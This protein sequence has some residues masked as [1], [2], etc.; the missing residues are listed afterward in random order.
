M[1]G[2]DMKQYA[3]SEAKY[4]I[5]ATNCEIW[6]KS[7]VRWLHISDMCYI[8]TRPVFKW[9]QKVGGGGFM[10]MQI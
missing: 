9:N 10:E 7:T 3:C 8:G 1:H 5:Y 4:L 6:V 2:W